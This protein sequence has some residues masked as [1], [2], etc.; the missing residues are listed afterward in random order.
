M[1]LWSTIFIVIV[2]VHQL[3]SSDFGRIV[4]H[5]HRD[6]SKSKQIVMNNGHCLPL[7][8]FG[9]WQLGNNSVVKRA[10]KSAITNGY[11][12]IDTADIYGNEQMI[13]DILQELFKEGIINRDDLFITTKVWCNHFSKSSVIKSIQQ[14]MQK[15]KVSYIDLVLLHYPTGFKENDDQDKY[16]K[17]K[18]GSIIPRTWKKD[19]YLETWES[20]EQ[21]IRNNYT[22]SIGVSNFN[23]RQ[24]KTLLSKATI[25]PVINQVES[26]PNLKQ[27]L[28]LKYLLENQIIMQA[29]APIRRADKELL[30]DPR[31]IAIGENHNK[32]SAHIAL[33][34][35]LQRSVPIV[36]KS[37]NPKRI[38]S[39]IQLFDFQLTNDEMKQIDMIDEKQRIYDINGLTNHPDYPFNEE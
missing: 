26:H 31:L 11:R 4:D 5:P 8:A 32:T 7:V 25:K 17:F 24:I 15:L 27:K 20:M 16:P 2:D 3:N 14:S 38:K 12:L 36:V 6:G 22:H 37:S 35:Q 30:N 9:T 1:C 10:I 39:N 21:A 13:G 18:N 34:W 28:L 33:R 19:S 23:R 29:Y